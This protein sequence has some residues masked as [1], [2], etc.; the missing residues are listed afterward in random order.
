MDNA[1]PSISNL[2]VVLKYLES[3]VTEVETGNL[4]DFKF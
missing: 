4:N 2:P 1:F 3:G